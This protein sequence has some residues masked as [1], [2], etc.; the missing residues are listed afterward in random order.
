MKR[1]ITQIE[2]G[3]LECLKYLHEINAP[4]D[5]RTFVTAKKKHQ[6]ECVK[7]LREINAP[8][9]IKALEDDDRK[10]Y[11]KCIKYLRENNLPIAS[12]TSQD[13]WLSPRFDTFL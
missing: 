11:A 6:S 10:S 1:G 2:N 8:T 3:Q 12:C 9:D 13:V 7:Y 4:I 5:A